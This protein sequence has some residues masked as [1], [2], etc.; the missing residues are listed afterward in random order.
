MQ[1]NFRESLLDAA[2]HFFMP[3][4]LQIGMQSALHQYTC[5]AKLRSLA[6]FLVDRVEI[7]DVSLFRPTPLN[8]TIERAEGLIIGAEVGVINIAVDDVRHGAFGMHLSADRVRFHANPDQVVGL[9]H[10]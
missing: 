9:K 5:P 3:L 6:N 2:Q 10:L 4:D 7:E 1:M 8:A